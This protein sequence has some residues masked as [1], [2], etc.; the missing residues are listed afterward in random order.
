MIWIFLYMS[1]SNSCFVFMSRYE[2]I[3]RVFVFYICLTCFYT[4]K[5]RKTRLRKTCNTGTRITRINTYIRITRINTDN[6]YNTYL[7]SYLCLI[8]LGVSYRV[9]RVV[10]SSCHRVTRIKFTC[11]SCRVA[12]NTYIKRVVFVFRIQTRF[13]IRVV[14]VF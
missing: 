1:F 9:T 14:F 13:I 3:K 2:F 8:V 10:V 5:T 11:Q 7:P 4:C 12:C 6:M